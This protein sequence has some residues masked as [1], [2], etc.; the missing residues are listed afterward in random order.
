MEDQQICDKEEDIEE[1]FKAYFATIFT[2]IAPSV[3]DINWCI[4]P[5]ESRVTESMN[6]TLNMEYSKKEVEEAL[7]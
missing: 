1:A 2:V 5:I 3:S 4:K 6:F 7:K